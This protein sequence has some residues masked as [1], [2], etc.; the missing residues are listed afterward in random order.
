LGGKKQVFAGRKKARGGELARSWKGF[1]FHPGCVYFY[2]NITVMI[3][4]I[5]YSLSL[6]LLL[7]NSY[8]GGQS[9]ALTDFKIADTPGVNTDA[10]QRLTNSV[11]N[12]FAVS[13]D[14]GQLQIR[15]YKEEDVMEL[16]LPQG[17]LLG[18]NYGEFGGGLYYKPADSTRPFFVNGRRGASSP[19][20]FLGLMVPV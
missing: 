11:V 13:M 9:I 1:D 17:R 8:C 16:D 14:G 5:F 10:W 2:L 4:K 3:N 20:F 7:C 12:D 15:R 6:S 18:V 19:A